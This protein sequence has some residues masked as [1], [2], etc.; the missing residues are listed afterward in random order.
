MHSDFPN[1]HISFFHLSAVVRANGLMAKDSN[2]TILV[3]QYF[4]ACP[5]YY[6]LWY[7]F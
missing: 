5:I 1:T 7:V 2:G 3:F 6:N 4:L